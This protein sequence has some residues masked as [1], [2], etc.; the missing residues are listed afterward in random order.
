MHNEDG[1]ASSRGWIDHEVD[2]NHLHVCSD[3]ADR[4]AM[5]LDMID[6]AQTS[7]KLYYYLFAD[8]ESGNM[9]LDRLIEAARRGVKITL[10]VDAFGTIETGTSF[11]QPLEEL[12][13]RVGW[14]GSSWSTRFLIRNHQKMAIADER[15]AIVGGFN[16]SDA[17]FGLAENNCWHDMGLRIDGPR[18]KTLVRWYDALDQWVF[19]PRQSFRALR[20]LVRGWH[21]GNDS[22]RWVIGGPTRI[23]SP[24]A[25]SVRH[26]LEKAQRLDMVAAYFTPGNRMLACI[27]RVARRGTAR[28]IMASKSDNTTTIAAARSLYGRLMQAGATIYEYQP[29]KLHM[30]LVVIDDAVYIGSANFDM[31]SLFVNL[32]IMVRINDAEF[33][34]KIRSFIDERSKDSEEITPEWYR[35]RKTLPQKLKGWLSYMLVG[36]VDYKV[37]RRLNLRE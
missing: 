22:I 37:T 29:C 11:F 14:Y 35:K 16:V 1:E 3:G 19:A 33:A 15:S 25:R 20:K 7:L 23:L 13:A 9:V 4:R 31:R 34:S 30:K 10:M 28:L 6:E 32:E 36:V 27:R 12:G 17:Y 5:L 26:D 24:W 2:G 18:V 21:D 8:D